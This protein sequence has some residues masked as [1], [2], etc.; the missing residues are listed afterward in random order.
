MMERVG[1]REERKGGRGHVRG[2]SDL[3][4][5]VTDW[6]QALRLCG[7]CTIGLDRINSKAGRVKLP[8]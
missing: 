8:T 2:L 6:W 1:T 5:G 7:W 3:L 4:C